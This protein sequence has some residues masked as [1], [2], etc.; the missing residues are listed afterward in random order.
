MARRSDGGEQAC[1]E[2]AL[3]LLG[4]R[5]HST[6]ELAGKLLRRGFDQSVVDCVTAD[7]TRLGLLNDLEFA[8][9]YCE[10]RL[11]GARA[12]GPHRIK[13]ELRR[14]GVTGP[15]AE[16]AL[17]RA[18]VEAGDE[19]DL[20]RALALAARKWPSMIRSADLRSARARLYRFLVRRG[21]DGT[22]VRDAVDRVAVDA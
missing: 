14:R 12:A 9:A 15:V 19:D 11:S 21:F 2:R 10:S 5:P 7:L 3:R 8:K 17:L 18:R 6:Y 22:T 20:D 4:T 1:R 16:E 13:M